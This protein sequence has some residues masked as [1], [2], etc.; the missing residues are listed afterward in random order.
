MFKMVQLAPYNQQNDKTF[1]WCGVK[2]AAET[3]TVDVSNELLKLK[4]QWQN[5]F[6]RV[7]KKNY[8]FSLFNSIH[9]K[10]FDP[11]AKLRALCYCPARH[12]GLNSN[13]LSNALV[14]RLLVPLFDIKPYFF[15]YRL[16]ATDTI[17]IVL[18]R[19]HT[20]CV[21][22]CVFF[23]FDSQKFSSKSIEEIGCWAN[24]V[25]GK[26]IKVSKGTSIFMWKLANQNPSKN[27]HSQ[28]KGQKERERLGESEQWQSGSY[29]FSWKW[30]S[31]HIIAEKCYPL[32]C[33][34]L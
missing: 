4:S 5:S 30:K 28:K 12:S 31:V 21:C 20:K 14:N 11:H 34:L 16:L 26:C 7:S 10:N 2:S 25:G 18:L 9:R 22:V 13:F 3:E 19:F 8:K 24:I 33:H 29:R 27:T 32:E 1:V 23:L 15:L 17:H 6:T